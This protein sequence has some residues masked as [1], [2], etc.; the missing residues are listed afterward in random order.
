MLIDLNAVAARIQRDTDPEKLL[1]K[2]AVS[3]LRQLITD[4]GIMFLEEAGNC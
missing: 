1:V 3:D 2:K 4:Q